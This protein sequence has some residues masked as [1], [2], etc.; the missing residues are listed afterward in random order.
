MDSAEGEYAEFKDKV[1]RTVYIDNLS[2]Q[3]TEAVLRS[4]MEQF[5]NVNKIHFIPNYTNPTNLPQC[6]LV[7]M[8]NLEQAKNI[9][10]V[11]NS[12]PFMISG[13]P[14]PVQVCPAEMEMFDDRPR[15]PGRKIICCWLNQQDPDFQVAKKI[16]SLVRK[17]DAEASHLLKLQLEEE[18]KLAKQQEDSL[19]AICKKF[20]LIDG[21]INEGSANHLARRYNMKEFDDS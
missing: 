12:F 1:K 9:V 14:R 4:A 15:K 8:E 10:S 20:E 13:M 7:E 17:H 11:M 21:V 6:A 3:I 18:Q 16:K 19:K 2:P 5:G